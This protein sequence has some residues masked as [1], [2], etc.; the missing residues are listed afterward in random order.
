[1]KKLVLLAGVALLAACGEREEA[2]APE[3]ATEAMSAEAAPAAAA[4]GGGVPGT[5]DVTQADGS[6]LVATLSADGT[7]QRDFGDR[8][9]KG[10]YVF[11]GNQTCFDPEGDVGESCNTRS[12]AAADGSFDSTDPK[13]AVNKVVPRS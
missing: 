11:K 13:G 1:M 4:V 6:K 7:Y 9:E 10:T 3:A 5:Y 2:A 8:V 12:P